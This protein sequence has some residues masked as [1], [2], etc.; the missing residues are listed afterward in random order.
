MDVIFTETGDLLLRSEALQLQSSTSVQKQSFE[1]KFL[2]A[3][4]EIPADHHPSNF[5]SKNGVPGDVVARVSPNRFTN[6]NSTPS[7][8]ERGA[9]CNDGAHPRRARSR[10]SE[11]L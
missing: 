4:C 1:E 10:G 7:S 6:L 3:V 2:H 9:C 5:F 11:A 8:T